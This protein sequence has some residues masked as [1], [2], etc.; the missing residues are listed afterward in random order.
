MGPGGPGGW[1]GFLSPSSRTPGTPWLFRGPLAWGLHP[2]WVGKSK[3][4]EE[5]RV[6]GERP[7]VSPLPEGKLGECIITLH[8]NFWG[9]P[10]L[11]PTQSSLPSAVVSP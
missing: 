3:A 1:K 7:G 2:W 10:S 6:S 9:L 8:L 11:V 4:R 5:S